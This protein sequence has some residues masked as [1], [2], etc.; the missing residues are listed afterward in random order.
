MVR[1]RLV[2]LPLLAGLA[3]VEA[4]LA[5]GMESVMLPAGLMAESMAEDG[6]WERCQKRSGAEENDPSGRERSRHA[7]FVQSTQAR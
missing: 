7:G 1:Y 3:G 4:L 6:V 2:T 5:S